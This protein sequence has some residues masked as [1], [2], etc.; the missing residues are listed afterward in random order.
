[1]DH[2]YEPKSGAETLAEKVAEGARRKNLDPVSAKNPVLPP[3]PEF[4]SHVD[5]SYRASD[6]RQFHDR[7]FVQM[8]YNAILKRPSDPEGLEYYLGQLRSGNLDQIEILSRLR[9]SPEGRAKGVLIN[10]LRLPLLLRR[11]RRKPIVG[12]LVR[13]AEELIFLPRNVRRRRRVE[14]HLFAR[15]QQTEEFIRER[16]AANSLAEVSETLTAQQTQINHLRKELD[17]AREEMR[18]RLIEFGMRLRPT[19]A[20]S[21]KMDALNAAFTDAF[22]GARAEIKERLSIY[23]PIIQNAA[24]GTKEMPIIDLGC[25]RGEWLEL[26]REKNLQARGVDLNRI[27]VAQSRELG[28]DVVEGDLIAYLGDLPSASVGAL[29]SFHVVEHLSPELLLKMLDETVRVLKPGG[30]VILETPNPQNI[31]VSSYAF[32]LDLSHRKPLPVPTLRFLF[33]SV[34]LERIEVIALREPV[35]KVEGDAELTERFNFF[36]YGSMDYAIVGW[37]DAG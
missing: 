29:T 20:E 9:F 32:H 17:A 3:P 7:E 10:G 31:N 35:D 33:K 30:V 6:F 36:F 23:L 21:S 1:M 5:G 14:G 24:I 18:A 8:A 34:G 15:Q 13:L 28:L 37:K 4:R 22:R 12:Y 19:K 25:G 16:S 11:A 26:L 2:L 27:F